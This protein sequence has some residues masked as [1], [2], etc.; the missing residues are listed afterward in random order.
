MEV[1]QGKDHGEKKEA[2]S[3]RKRCGFLQNIRRA[4]GQGVFDPPEERSPAGGELLSVP[5][6]VPAFEQEG[7]H[8][9]KGAGSKPEEDFPSE[10]PGPPRPDD[11]VQ[12]FIIGRFAGEFL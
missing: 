5:L 8:I 1:A 10:K 12:I 9:L 4:P 2:F 6:A 7:L 11:G 3:P